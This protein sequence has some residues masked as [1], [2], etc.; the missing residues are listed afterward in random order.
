MASPSSIHDLLVEKGLEGYE[1]KLAEAGYE[2]LDDLA[3][4]EEKE[5]IEEV[6]MKRPHARRLLA[7]A[8]SVAAS[9][10]GA[11]AVSWR[12]NACSPRGKSLAASRPL[13]GWR[14]S[15]RGAACASQCLSRASRSKSPWCSRKLAKVGKWCSWKRSD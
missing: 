8:K 7:A 13:G 10:A 12:C 11:G 15:R 6:S 1:L 3:E 5:L 14:R 4:A 9:G 2:T